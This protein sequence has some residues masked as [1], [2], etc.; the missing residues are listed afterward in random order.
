MEFVNWIIVLCNIFICGKNFMAFLFHW[1]HLSSILKWDGIA[2]QHSTAQRNCFP[3]GLICPRIRRHL[4]SAALA[5]THHPTPVAVRMGVRTARGI[6]EPQ[7]TVQKTR[8]P[9]PVLHKVDLAASYVGPWFPRTGDL[10]HPTWPCPRHREWLRDP[11]TLCP[12]GRTPH[13][14]G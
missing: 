9:G 3:F 12:A 6:V 10:P 11:R 14:S 8:V 2:T 1:L 5:V 4:C 7:A 13:L